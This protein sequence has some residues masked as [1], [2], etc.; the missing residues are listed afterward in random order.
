M[1][2]R[3]AAAEAFQETSIVLWEKFGEYDRSRDFKAWV[4]GIARNKALASIRDRQRQRL[5]FSDGLLNQL[6]EEAER[7]APSCKPTTRPRVFGIWNG[8]PAA[9]VGEGS[10]VQP[11][12]GRLMLRL[13]PKDSGP[14]PYRRIEQL[15]DVSAVVPPEGCTVEASFAF[16]SEFPKQESRYV[17]KI[18]AFDR[19]LETSGDVGGNLMEIAFADARRKFQVKKDSHRWQTGSIRMEL[20]PGTHMIMIDITARNLPDPYVDKAHFIDDVQATLIVPTN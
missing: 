11:R 5:V 4:F 18:F 1:P 13:E 17:I 14:L 19:S 12:E 20:P 15:I 8:D 3:E 6:A 9:V 10:G 16:R 2:S 7:M